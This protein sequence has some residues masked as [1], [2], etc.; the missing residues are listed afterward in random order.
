MRLEIP[1]FEYLDVLFFWTGRDVLMFGD[2]NQLENNSE[3]GI[4]AIKWLNDFKMF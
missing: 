2:V 1:L 3:K 4:M